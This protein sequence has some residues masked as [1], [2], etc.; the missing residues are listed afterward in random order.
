MEIFISVN[1]DTNE[2]N[3]W[4]S[5]L[6]GEDVFKIDLELGHDFFQSP[7]SYKFVNN[8]LVKDS[9]GLLESAKTAKDEELNLACEESI[10][11]G[12]DFEVNGVMYHFSFDME[13]QLNFQGA[14]RA[15]VNGLTESIMW[16]VTNIETGQKERILITQELMTAL[17]LEILSHKNRN[18]SRYRDELGKQLEAATTVEEV[19]AIHW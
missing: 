15:F 6:E 11:Q 5:S 19:K 2:I 10:L 1:K 8:E 17:S 3:G 18:I 14:E 9:E 12:F 13:A 16:T 7:M 4:G